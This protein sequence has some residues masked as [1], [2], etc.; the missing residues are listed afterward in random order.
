[1][2]KEKKENN[3]GLQQLEKDLREKNYGM[4]YV[5]YG[6]EVFLRDQYLKHLKSA[7]LEAGTEA[8]NFHEFDGKETSVEALE[9]AINCFPMMAERSFVLVTDWDIFKMNEGA[10]EDLIQVLEQLPDYCTVVFFFD[11]VKYTG[12]TRTKLASTIA[13]VGVF[14]DF[15]CKKPR[16]L[17]QW[18]GETFYRLG[19]DI[20]PQVVEEFI[21]Y[22]GNYMTKLSGEIEKIAAYASEKQVKLEDVYAVASPHLD[23]VAFD[24]SDALGQQNYDKALGILSDLYQMQEAPQKI[25]GAVTRQL[26]LMYGAKLALEQGKGEQ[27]IVKMMGLHPYAGKLTTQNARRVSLDWCRNACILSAQTDK[28]MKSTG[29]NPETLLVQLLLDLA[30]G[31]QVGWRN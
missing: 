29:Q 31:G 5:F 23:A 14:V 20:T 15:H 7:L 6:E 30:G 4:L 1:M 3:E 18:V 2:A 9:E 17:Q 13:K 16:E 26:R 22:C 21:F 10:R 24:L 19:K 8:F 11:R 27:Y 12:D 28:A 25:M